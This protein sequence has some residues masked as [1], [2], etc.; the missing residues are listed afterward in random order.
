[1]LAAVDAG[2]FTAADSLLVAFEATEAGTPAASE[3]AFWR[4]LLRTDPRN[5]AFSPAEAR[6]ALEAHLASPGAARRTE[7]GVLLRLLGIADSLRNA[8]ASA[9]TA[10]EQRD[11]AREDELHRLRDELQRTQAELERI[12][13]RLGPPKP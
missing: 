7:A 4:A 2:Q 9:R 10:S 12:K 13:R 11:R 8:Q 5:P 1:V 6:A 3:S